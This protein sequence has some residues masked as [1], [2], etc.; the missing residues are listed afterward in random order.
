MPS[1]SS[2]KGFVLTFNGAPVCSL[3]IFF[4]IAPI[5]EYTEYFVCF[6]AIRAEQRIYYVHKTSVCTGLHRSDFGL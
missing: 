4:V 5:R 2:A 6:F 3:S 1:R